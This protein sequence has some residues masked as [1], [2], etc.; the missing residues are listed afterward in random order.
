MLDAVAYDLTHPGTITIQNL[1]S[2]NDY[3]VQ[4]WVSGTTGD[5]VKIMYTENDLERLGYNEKKAFI[6]AGVTAD[7]T[8][9]LVC[10]LDRC[11][12][13][14][15]AYFLGVKSLG[16][17]AIRSGMNHLD[18]QRHVLQ[19]TQPNVIVGVPSFLRRLG[20]YLQV[21]NETTILNRIERIIC[22]GES[23]R[24]IPLNLLPVGTELEEIFNAKVFSTYASSETVTTFC[25]C[26]AQC[27]GHLHPDLAIVEI[28][29]EN[30]N[31]V[32]DGELGE[33]VVT[34][35]QTEGMPLIR[36]KTGDI[37]FKIPKPCSCGRN[38]VRLGPILGRRQQ[39]LKIK[40]TTLYPQ[41]I[42][43]ILSEQPG[44]LEYYINI[45]NDANLIDQC[46]ICV[47]IDDL[48][49]YEQLNKRLNAEL[50]LNLPLKIYPID[51]IKQKVF[52]PISR[53]PIRVFDSR[54]LRK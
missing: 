19:E 49:T 13:A 18:S 3:M 29:D 43:N 53:K 37:S 17:T 24:D 11:F 20:N 48:I 16:A 4:I 36:F 41:M 5:A 27:G 12:V 33:V 51:D 38:S 21:K 14:G 47:A 30:N 1:T 31:P 28:L 7:D 9:M 10:T 45:S 26:E 25:E 54:K 6:G 35:L 42:F 32:N 22:I 50:R 52:T 46:E 2:G 39:M 40:G 15:L 44:V 23:I 8:V 34:P